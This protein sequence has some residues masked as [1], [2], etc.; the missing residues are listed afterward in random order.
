[1]KFPR[2][3]ALASLA[4]LL[5]APL[6]AQTAAAPAAT[7]APK[8]LP[9]ARVAWLNSSAFM[10]EGG[11]IKQLIKVLKELEL[12]FSGTESELSLLNE[13][14]RT[15][16]GELQ[17]LQ[18]G[19]E[20]NAAAIQEKQT[21]GI[22]MQR[23]LQQKQQAAQQAIGAAQQEKQAPIAAQISKALAEFTKERNIDLLLDAA[24][25]GD[26]VLIAKPELD[27]TADFIAYFNAKNP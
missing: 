1:M 5:V 26:A 20:A 19:G 25:L 27:V 18:A 6:T 21:Q 8:V 7:A 22:Q 13:K 15:L 12:E 24:K 2:F 23:E 9:T 3:L 17:K 16:V 14:L 11:G 4:T 10:E